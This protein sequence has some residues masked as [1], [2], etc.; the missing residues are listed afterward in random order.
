MPAV[1]LLLAVP[2]AAQVGILCLDLAESRQKKHR[3]LQ[4]EDWCQ[5]V[6]PT[7]KTSL[8]VQAAFLQLDYVALS[9]I[10]FFF[11]LALNLKQK[12]QSPLW[13]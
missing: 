13:N 5:E 9:S 3:V 11:F 1:I 10:L 6:N 8:P 12:F 4:V 2:H 7:V